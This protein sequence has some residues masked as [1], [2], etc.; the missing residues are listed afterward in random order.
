VVNAVAYA[1][2]PA[3]LIASYYCVRT[4]RSKNGLNRRNIVLSMILVTLVFYLTRI[5]INEQYVI[6]FLGLGLI[7][8]YWIGS[9]KR[10]KE[11]H[12]LWIS[13]LAYLIAHNSI[14]IFL[15][16]ISKYYATLYQIAVPSELSLG[17]M[18]IT[19]ISFSIFSLLYLRSVY[20][21]LKAF[22][23]KGAIR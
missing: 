5:Q 18:L 13:A 14:F 6:Y 8:Y 20:F 16:P 9:V 15:S 23:L 12:G 4:L 21:E 22:T 17:A 7:D 19:A 11:F 3:I 1:W 10:L 2:V